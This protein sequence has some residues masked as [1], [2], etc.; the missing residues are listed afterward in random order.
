MTGVT[1]AVPHAELHG[2]QQPA[3][4]FAGFPGRGAYE[5]E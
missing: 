2:F 1:F 3:H 4:R 5:R